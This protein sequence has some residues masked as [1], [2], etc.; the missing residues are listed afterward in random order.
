MEKWEEEKGS[1]MFDVNYV[2]DGDLCDSE[3]I[4]RSKYCFRFR[5][6]PRDK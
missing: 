1:P 6:I 5:T 2:A 3:D 4:F